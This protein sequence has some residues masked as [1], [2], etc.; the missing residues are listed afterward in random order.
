MRELFLVVGCNETLADCFKFR[1]KIGLDAALESLKI[2]RK[3]RRPQ[4]QKVLD[5]ARICRVE[6]VLRPYLEAIA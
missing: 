2:Y 6:K 3:R 4:F 1:D 5:Y